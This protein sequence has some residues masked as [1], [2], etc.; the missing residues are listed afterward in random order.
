PAAIDEAVAYLSR[1]GIAAGL[2][3]CPL[4]ES[5]TL[6]CEHMLMSRYEAERP[7]DEEACRAGDA[8]VLAMRAAADR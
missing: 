2:R 3:E 7:S 5:A 4:P 6:A 1:F 8:R